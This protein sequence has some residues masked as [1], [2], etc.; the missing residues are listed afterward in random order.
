MH[1]LEKACFK[2]LWI[3][4]P[5]LINRTNKNKGL[6]PF[7]L[8]NLLIIMHRQ[9]QEQSTGM[10]TMNMAL[11]VISQHTY[12]WTPVPA[13]LTRGRVGAV[14]GGRGGGAVCAPVQRAPRHDSLK[15]KRKKKDRRHHIPTTPHVKPPIRV[16]LP[17]DS[18][19]QRLWAALPRSPLWSQALPYNPW[20][21][22]HEDPGAMAWLYVSLKET[23][24]RRRAGASA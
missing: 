21:L 9:S 3:P 18:T 4:T 7:D 6:A 8:G 5:F 16:T 22:R 15:K 1:W 24:A 17:A 13:L 19:L 2:T 12:T 10:I 11:L 23:G 20:Q 14:L